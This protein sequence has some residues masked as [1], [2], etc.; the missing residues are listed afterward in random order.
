MESNIHQ[1]HCGL[2]FHCSN[3]YQL[4][5]GWNKASLYNVRYGSM[6]TLLLFFFSCCL[7]LSLLVGFL[8]VLQH[9][10]HHLCLFHWYR[11][12]SGGVCCALHHLNTALPYQF[13]RKSSVCVF[14]SVEI[15]SEFLNTAQACLQHYFLVNAHCS[16]V[17]PA[18]TDSW[19]Q[20]RP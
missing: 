12:T 16:H 9:Y 7:F 5:F 4:W 15:T 8:L 20:I 17:V 10:P 6:P 11:L 18:A 19:F 1:N 14:D 13:N 2:S 3:N